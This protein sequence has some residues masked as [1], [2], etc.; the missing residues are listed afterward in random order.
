MGDLV[1]SNSLSVQKPANYRPLDKEQDESHYFIL[2]TQYLVCWSNEIIIEK[3]SRQNRREQ[4]RTKS[5]VPRAQNDSYQKKDR[6]YGPI[7]NE[8]ECGGNRKGGHYK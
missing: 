5:A 1:R 2:V 6:A 8:P 3:Q 4:T 7:N